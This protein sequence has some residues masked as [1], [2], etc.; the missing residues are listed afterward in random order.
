MSAEGQI[1]ESKPEAN[2]IP[3]GNISSFEG[4]EKAPQEAVVIKLDKPI[5]GALP[6]TTG[7]SIRLGLH[8]A[9]CRFNNR[10]GFHRYRGR[11]RQ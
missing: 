5:D 7:R 9:C 3:V 6:D 2:M 11:D 8:R 4:K 10:N 1:V